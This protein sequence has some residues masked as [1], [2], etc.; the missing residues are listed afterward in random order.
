MEIEVGDLVRYVDVQKADDI[1][2]IRI[3]RGTS[4]LVNGLIS[5]TTPLAQALLGATTGDEVPLHLPANARRI[6][7]VVAILKPRPIAAD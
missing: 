2:S 7:R 6:F 5:E 4:D 1:L 3:T